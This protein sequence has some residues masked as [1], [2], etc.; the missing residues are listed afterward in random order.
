MA[1]GIAKSGSNKQKRSDFAALETKSKCHRGQYQF[2]D[3]IVKRELNF[4]RI[5]NDRDTKTCIP[6]RNRKKVENNGDDDS[7]RECSK[8][9]MRKQ[10]LREVFNLIRQKRKQP[11]GQTEEDSGTD[12]PKAAG[13]R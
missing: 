9:Q 10:F 6:S 3:P 7:A 2:S 1:E 4:Q 12:G 5:N 13:A 11:R 8:R